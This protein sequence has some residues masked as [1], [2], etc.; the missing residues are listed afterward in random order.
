MASNCRVYYGS[1]DG[2]EA[3]ETLP[4]GSVLQTLWDSPTGR[5]AVWVKTAEDEWTEKFTHAK[6]YPFPVWEGA[7]VLTHVP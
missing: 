4:V 5:G 2:L 6:A 1:V 7:L 3:N